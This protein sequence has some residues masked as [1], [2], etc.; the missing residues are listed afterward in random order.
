[1][2]QVKDYN[3]FEFGLGDKLY[4]LQE[5]CTRHLRQ[6][7]LLNIFRALLYKLKNRGFFLS[8]LDEVLWIY[9]DLNFNTHDFYYLIFLSKLIVTKNPAFF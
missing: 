4:I 1:L 5:L 2:T 8:M 6:H 9:V 3:A 7:V